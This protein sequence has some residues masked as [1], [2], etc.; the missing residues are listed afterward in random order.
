MHPTVFADHV[1]K[2]DLCSPPPIN[3]TINDTL[4]IN[5]VMFSSFK[6]ALH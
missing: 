2:L 6:Q 1:H 5:A 4:I 3:V